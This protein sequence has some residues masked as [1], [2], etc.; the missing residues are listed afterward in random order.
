[1]VAEQIKELSPLTAFL[2]LAI[3]PAATFL[4]FSLNPIELGWGSQLARRRQPFA[5][6]PQA[7]R[8]KADA[9]TRYLN[10]LVDGLISG[11]IVVVLHRTA[12]GP[13]NVGLRFSNW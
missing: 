6:M 4:G 1:L 12:L 8:N 9:V 10:F 7:L 3:Y 2:A 11:L 13:A 5:P